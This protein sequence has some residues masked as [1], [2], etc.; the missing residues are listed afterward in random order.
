MSEMRREETESNILKVDLDFE[1]DESWLKIWVETRRLIL[2]HY[3]IKIVKILPHKSSRGTN[4]FIHIDR[5]LDSME[6]LLFQFLL[7]DDATRCKINKWRI[8]RGIQN[9]NKLFSRKIYR[10]NA[11]YIECQY[12]GNKIMIPKAL[13]GRLNEQN[14][15]IGKETA[16]G[17]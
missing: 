16:K 13:R 14:D 5:E 1:P 7:G 2:R 10:K 8:E 11:R 12:C 6:R 17:K 4:F 9:W 3:G 15:K